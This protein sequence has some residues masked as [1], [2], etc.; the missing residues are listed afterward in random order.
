MAL[1]TRGSHAERDAYKIIKNKK[2]VRSP[3][4]KRIRLNPRTS[5]QLNGFELNQLNRRH[6]GQSGFRHTNFAKED[7]ASI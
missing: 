6:D 2:D 4:A 5:Q 3:A 7:V 1:E